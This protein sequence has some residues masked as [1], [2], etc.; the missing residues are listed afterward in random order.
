MG[1]PSWEWSQHRAEQGCRLG[2]SWQPLRSTLASAVS[3][4]NSLCMFC[5]WC[6]HISKT[7][8]YLCML[9]VW[10]RWLLPKRGLTHWHH[11]DF[12]NFRLFKEGW[13]F[14]VSAVDP[15]EHCWAK[16]LQIYIFHVPSQMK[17]LSILKSGWTDG[18]T[19]QNTRNPPVPS[20]PGV[21]PTSW[22][23][24]FLGYICPFQENKS[25][26]FI[27]LYPFLIILLSHLSL[28]N[29]SVPVFLRSGKCFIQASTRPSKRWVLAA[30]ETPM[31]S[32][33]KRQSEEI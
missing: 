31:V 18:P 25:I 33:G 26:P 27:H 15:G 4:P 6:W 2:A 1:F 29:P 32:K 13:V 9:S 17:S 20:G 16:L 28:L 7:N 3:Y 8:L 11:Q 24:C 23:L 10:E 5:C 14:W 22:A 12:L 21:F 30:V 19:T